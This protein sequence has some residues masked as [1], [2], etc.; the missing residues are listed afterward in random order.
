[1]QTTTGDEALGLFIVFF[2]ISVAVSIFVIRIGV[3]AITR[4]L[5]GLNKQVSYLNGLLYA[6]MKPPHEP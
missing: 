6:R 3:Q 2:L 1:M 4:E 5:Q